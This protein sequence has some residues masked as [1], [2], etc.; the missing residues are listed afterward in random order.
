MSW[1]K[2]KRQESNIPGTAA[3]PIQAPSPGSSSVLPKLPEIKLP[4]LPSISNQPRPQPQAAVSARPVPAPPRAITSPPP[5]RHE[6]QE[7][8][9]IFVKID[10]FKDAVES[11]EKVKERVNEIENMLRRIK[12]TKQKEDQELREWEHEIQII[13]TKV[14]NIDSSLFK[15]IS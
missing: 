3:S 2:K 8:E 13:K 12:E 5:V 1:F 9:P 15:K 10:K 14:I 6:I 7:K 11:F 4:N